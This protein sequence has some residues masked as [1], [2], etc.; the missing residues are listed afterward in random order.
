LKKVILLSAGFGKRL[1]PLTD[2]LPKPLMSINGK[3]LLSIWLNRLIKFG[4][5]S[6]L[7]NSHYLHDKIEF[8]IKNSE[9]KDLI[10]YSYEKNIL[11]TAGT[12]LNNLD[13]LSDG[14]LLVHADNYCLADFEKFYQA[15]I[16]RPK[17]CL[18][19][20]MTFTTL[21]PEKCGIVEIN[22]ENIVKNF[23]EKD[24]KAKGNIANAAIYYLSKDMIC[25][26]QRD[27]N[28]CRDFST[29]ILPNFINKIYTWHSD[30]PLIDIGTPKDY[31]IANEID[32]KNNS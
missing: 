25:E 30:D 27:Y 21:S 11:G 16:N 20:M 2:S 15:H 32:K 14:G 23:F 9:H 24:L 5:S 8:F 4:F 22:E 18:M 13:F 28:H 7:I 17:S 3:P 10:T 29:E 6:F 31:K 1:R 19:T 12:I 26:I